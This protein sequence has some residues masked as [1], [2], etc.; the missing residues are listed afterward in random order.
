MRKGIRPSLS[1]SLCPT[2]VIS[3]S[4]S[5]SL[6]LH[7]HTYI[8]ILSSRSN[9]RRIPRRPALRFSGF[10]LFSATPP[11]RRR[12]KRTKR[13]SGVS[14]FRFRLCS[15]PAP[16]RPQ[17]KPKRGRSGYVCF[18]R[19]S[20]RFGASPA[21]AAGK[22]ERTRRCVL[23]YVFVMC[24]CVF[25]P[26]RTTIRFFLPIFGSFRG[27]ARGGGRG[28]LRGRAGVFCTMFFSC[29][30]VFFSP[31]RLGRKTQQNRRKTWCK[32]QPCF[33]P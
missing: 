21:A 18:F 7:T 10:R 11:R 14:R 26:G 33:A 28:N 8:Y 17:G 19:Y 30:A 27:L 22:P 25:L 3:P 2:R 13:K 24:C 12:G 15:A 1:L 6:V 29:F 20:G 5:L 32:T 9:S 23:H 16:R 31:R 4:L